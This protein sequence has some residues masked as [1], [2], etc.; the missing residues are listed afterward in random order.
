LKVKIFKHPF[1]C[2]ATPTQIDVKFGVKKK[3]IS[4]EISQSE[5][6]N[7]PLNLCIFE[8]KIKITNWGKLLQKTKK[9]RRLGAYHYCIFFNKINVG[10]KCSCNSFPIVVKAH[11]TCSPCLLK[12]VKALGA[13]HLCLRPTLGLRVQMPCS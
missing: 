2:F 3:K 5:Y 1:I 12:G 8:I 10:G 13:R 4:L 7:S 11:H 6:A 9:K